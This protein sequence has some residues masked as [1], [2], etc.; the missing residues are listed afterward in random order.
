VPHHEDVG[1]TDIKLHAFYTSALNGDTSLTACSVPFT[2]RKEPPLS[3]GYE[4]GW[5]QEPVQM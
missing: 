1:G 5:I 3:T 4:V 2:P